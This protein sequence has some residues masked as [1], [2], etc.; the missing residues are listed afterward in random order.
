MDKGH[1]ESLGEA[2]E[3]CRRFPPA[4]A[5]V[6]KVRVRVRFKVRVRDKVRDRVKIRV[7]LKGI[8]R[9]GIP[10]YC[11]PPVRIKDNNFRVRVQVRVRVRV[12]YVIL[13][14]PAA[15]DRARSSSHSGDFPQP[16]LFLS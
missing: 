5:R 6:N 8:V 15:C 12:P 11:F 7:R 9:H 3:P 4:R 1:W 10:C 14:L 13:F 16:F 2:R